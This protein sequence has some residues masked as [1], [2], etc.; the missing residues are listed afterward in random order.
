MSHLEPA[1]ILV[2]D[3]MVILRELY[4]RFLQNEGME[5]VLA[6]DGAAALALARTQTPDLVVSDLTMPNMDGLE[7]CR[8]LRSDPVT[9]DVPIVIV[10][11]Q[12]S[13]QSKAAAAAGCDAV[14]EKPCSGVLLVTTIRILL[15]RRRPPS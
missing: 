6:T 14:L 11:G 8:A 13:A 7:L 9:K 2:V 5:V 15:S 4:G 1:Q 3:D 12:G 10:T